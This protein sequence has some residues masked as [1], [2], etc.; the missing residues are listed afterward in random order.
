MLSGNMRSLCPLLGVLLGVWLTPAR[1][2][3][4]P[5]AN[6][7]PQAASVPP[8]VSPDTRPSGGG[9][10]TVLP[11]SVP[12]PAATAPQARPGEYRGRNVVLVLIDGVRQQEWNGQALDE[13]GRKVRLSELFPNLLQLRKSGIYFPK[14][15]ISNPVGVSLPAY[16]DI[17]AGRRQERILSNGP[18]VADFR[19]HYPT[20]FQEIKRQL[21]LPFDGVALHASWTP[22]CTISQTAPVDPKEDFYRSCGFRSNAQSPAQ[23]F[24]PEVYGGSRTDIDTFLEVMQE[25]PKRT[26]RLL[27]IHLGDADE[28]AH[29]HNKVQSKVGQSYGI[30][31][32][33]QA[34]RQDD[35]LLGRIW[36]MLQAHPLYRN[37][38]YLFVSTDH[39][40]DSAFDPNQWSSHGRCVAEHVR[41]K[42]CSGCSGIFAVAVGPGLTPHTA[43]GSY[44]HIDLAPTIARILNA[45]LPT[46]TGRVMREITD[47]LPLPREE[48]AAASTP[49]LGKQVSRR[50][51]LRTAQWS[52]T[53]PA[54]KLSPSARLRAPA[55]L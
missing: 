18:P 44:S 7:T 40:R 37:N 15:Q 16:A 39:G 11:G 29:L 23:Y 31:H 46:A 30:F 6:L 12:S 32:Y 21:G 14:M 47:T 20:F 25:V 41:T 34:L 52:L 42:P 17:F 36:A 2:C 35:Y 5:A 43:K 24:K 26:P 48:G 27:V 4:Q 38:T 19:S 13:N 50:R 53:A 45:K 22:L 51:I 3:A 9:A 33:H 1:L 8:A 49:A 10:G 28:E 54:A 55:R